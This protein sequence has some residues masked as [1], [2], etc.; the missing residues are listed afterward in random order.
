MLLFLIDIL[1][2]NILYRLAFIYLLNRLILLDRLIAL[3]LRP[4]NLLNFLNI[5]DLILS[6]D[7]IVNL[8]LKLRK[9]LSVHFFWNVN[10]TRVR[11]IIYLN[12]NIILF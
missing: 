6:D 1:L 2:L 4:H 12:D 10:N 3:N 7:S 5:V 9:T 11:L 8:F